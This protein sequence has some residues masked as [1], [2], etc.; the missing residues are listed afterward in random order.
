MVPIELSK[1]DQ[2]REDIYGDVAAAGSLP[3]RITEVLRTCASP[4]SAIAG[5][6]IPNFP[7]YARVEHLDRFSQIYIA[8][9]ERLFLADFWAAGV[10][11]AEMSSSNLEEVAG[12]IDCW[13]R[14]RLPIRMFAE[15][16]SLV[17]PM[18]GVEAFEDGTAVEQRWRAYARSVPEEFPDLGEFVRAAMLTPELRQLFPFMSLRVF[19]FSRCTGYPYT[20]DCP[21]V[22]SSTAGRY[23]VLQ[24]NG[25]RS[26]PMNAA[27]AVRL[28]VNS[29]PPN[30]G[31][32][33]SGTA[34]DLPTP[35]LPT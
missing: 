33:R 18:S 23:V 24:R 32:A 9:N 17:R 27:E 16:Y 6:Q 5:G 2:L 19:C 22:F 7:I 26:Q 29:L 12:P 3:A 13:L 8:R 35:T 25:D 10:Q 30:C 4:L 34:D 31:P 28:V 11:F 1:S 15:R 21:S 20:R 14:E